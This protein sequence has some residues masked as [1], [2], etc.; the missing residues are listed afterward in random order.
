MSTILRIRQIP[1]VYVSFTVLTF[2]VVGFDSMIG[3][4]PLVPKTLAAEDAPIN[5][6]LLV[7]GQDVLLVRPF[8]QDLS[9]QVAWVAA[10][11]GRRTKPGICDERGE[12]MGQST[13]QNDE[14]MTLM[15]SRVPSPQ[16]TDAIMPKTT[17]RDEGSNRGQ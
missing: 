2:G 9:A 8:R 4:R 7:N 6:L 14:R 5:G 10:N 11:L 17:F 16:I 1:G 12:Q 3:Q 15:T 13:S